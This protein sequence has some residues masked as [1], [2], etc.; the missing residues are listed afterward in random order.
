MKAHLHLVRYAI[1]SGM[2]VSVFDG[3]RWS[4]NRSQSVREI[5][6]TIEA[7]DEC[8]LRF[9]NMFDG[10]EGQADINLDNAPEESVYD[11]TTTDF[12]NRWWAEF[13]AQL[14]TAL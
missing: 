3:E 9:R 13:E 10:N 1:N 14:N 6:Q 2:K 5:M 11:F 8:T 4:V 7:V 12:L